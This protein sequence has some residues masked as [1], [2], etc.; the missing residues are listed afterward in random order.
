MGRGGTRRDAGRLSSHDME[1][2]SGGRYYRLLA[3]KG[4]HLACQSGKVDNCA[5]VR[6]V[7]CCGAVQ[8]SM[9]EGRSRAGA[10]TDIPFFHGGTSNDSILLL[11]ALQ[12]QLRTSYTSPHLSPPVGVCHHIHHSSDSCREIYGDNSCFCVKLHTRDDKRSSGGAN[13][14]TASQPGG[15]REWISSD[16][17]LRLL[18]LS[19]LKLPHRP[20]FHNSR[21]SNWT[22][23]VTMT[24]HSHALFRFAGLQSVGDRSRGGPVLYPVST[25]HH[26]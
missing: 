4:S 21:V 16:L 24:P 19:R 10:E 20:I 25:F 2:E 5:S 15:R 13:D 9:Y 6:V 11:P 14:W 22:V 12:L 3:N 7:G 1:K 23:L 18:R 26:P 17:R 8:C